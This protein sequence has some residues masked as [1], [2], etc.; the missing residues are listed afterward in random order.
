MHQ[1]RDATT[2]GVGDRDPQK[3]SNRTYAP[4]LSDGGEAV[5]G[6]R[7]V[8][9]DVHVG[10]VLVLVDAHHEHRGVPGRCADHD[11]DGSSTRQ[12]KETSKAEEGA[13]SHERN[14]WIDSGIP[15]TR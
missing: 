11:L 15:D 9:H 2:D 13:T 8:G 14:L 7:C 12:D 3:T 6:A 1:T 4:H 5:G 10:G